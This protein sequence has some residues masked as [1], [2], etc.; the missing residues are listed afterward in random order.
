LSGGCPSGYVNVFENYEIFLFHW[1]PIGG[2]D[3]RCGRQIGTSAS[4][5]EVSGAKSWPGADYA[6][7][8]V[9]MH[10]LVHLGKNSNDTKANKINRFVTMVY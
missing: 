10:F 1:V 4:F 3:R 9:S 2:I 6:M 7:S 5:S 8:F